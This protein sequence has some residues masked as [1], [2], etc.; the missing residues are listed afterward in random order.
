[1]NFFTPNC[2][3]ISK[4]EKDL[5]FKGRRANIIAKGFL[6]LTKST[7]KKGYISK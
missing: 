6:N 7:N 3:S 4:R 5:N 2:S 1:M